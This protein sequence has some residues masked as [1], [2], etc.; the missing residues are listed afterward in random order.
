[1]T[2]GIRIDIGPQRFGIENYED[3]IERMHQINPEIRV[4]ACEYVGSWIGINTVILSQC[5]QECPDW[6]YSMDVDMSDCPR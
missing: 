2:S 5:R 6:F 4:G 1:M 3:F